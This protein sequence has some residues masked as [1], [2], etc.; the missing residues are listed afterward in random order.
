MWGTS[1]EGLPMSS[2]GYAMAKNVEAGDE[3]PVPSKPEGIKVSPELD[4][5]LHML[6]ALQARRSN[7]NPQT[8]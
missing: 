6:N 2:N 7:G 8:G 4:E 1:K 5:V 3:D